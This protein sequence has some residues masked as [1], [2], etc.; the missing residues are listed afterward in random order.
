MDQ[1][2]DVRAVVIPGLIE[3]NGTVYR[4]RGYQLEMLEASRQQS[5]IVAVG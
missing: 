4:P 5:I 3:S 1:T 2:T